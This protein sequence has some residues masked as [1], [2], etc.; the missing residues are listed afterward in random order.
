M[1]SKDFHISLLFIFRCNKLRSSDYYFDVTLAH[2]EYTRRIAGFYD[3]DE[4]RLVEHETRLTLDR[5]PSLWSPNGYGD[6]RLYRLDVAANYK[7]RAGGWWRL[8]CN[9][10]FAVNVFRMEERPV[11]SS[12]WFSS[13]RT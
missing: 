12:C 10:S 4:D 7:L 8:K 1:P 13:H 11:E 2:L 3:C 9:V 5:P 6:Q